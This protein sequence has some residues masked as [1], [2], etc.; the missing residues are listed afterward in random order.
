MESGDTNRISLQP[1]AIRS[2][3][4]FADSRCGNPASQDLRG[5]NPS[6]PTAATAPSFVHIDGLGNRAHRT[7]SRIRFMSP[8]FPAFPGSDAQTGISRCLPYPSQ[9]MLQGLPPLRAAPGLLNRIPLG[10]SPS[11]CIL[12]KL[13]RTTALVRKLLQYY[14]TVRLPM[15]VHR[16]RAPLGF[17]ARAALPSSRPTMGFSRLPRNVLRCAHGVSRPRRVRIAPRVSGASSVAPRSS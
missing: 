2:P 16:H 7:R 5:G 17:I 1:S 6:P 10:S 3:Q 14:G 11:L 12:R 9:R 13:W 8:H 4:R 15:V